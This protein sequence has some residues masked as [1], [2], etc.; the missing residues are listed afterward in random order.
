M[1]ENYTGSFRGVHKKSGQLFLL[2]PSFVFLFRFISED[3]LWICG[4]YAKSSY[5]KFCRLKKYGM[6]S[7]QNYF[8]DSLPPNYRSDGD[9]SRSFRILYDLSGTFRNSMVLP[10]IWTFLAVPVSR[11]H[12][13]SF[14]ISEPFH[15]RRFLFGILGRRIPDFKAKKIKR[16]TIGSIITN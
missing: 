8:Y 4:Q 6:N 13:V 14:Y 5:Q 1:R 16:S 3:I 12:G 2:W 11:R 7:G 10:D 15:Y 9:R